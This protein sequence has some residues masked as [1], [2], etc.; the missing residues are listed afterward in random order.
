MAVT[1]S[2]A[3][4]I[5]DAPCG[6]VG[7]HALGAEPREAL[8][9]LAEDAGDHLAVGFAVGRGGGARRAGRVLRV[10]G[11]ARVAV[12]AGLP[13]RQLGEEAAGGEIVGRGKVARRF[14]RRGGDPRRLQAR[15]QAA[16]AAAPSPKA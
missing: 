8:V 1:S 13:V 11:Q 12:G 6:H 7:H 2:R 14:H 4:F 15:R 3:S 16:R 5:S 10:E 9:I